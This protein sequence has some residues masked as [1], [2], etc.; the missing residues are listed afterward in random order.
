MPQMAPLNWLFLFI[1]FTASFLIL[2]P[3]NFFSFNYS[4]KKIP[5]KSTKSQFNWK[6]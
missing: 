1:F 3:V 5:L 6:W 4:I 2:N